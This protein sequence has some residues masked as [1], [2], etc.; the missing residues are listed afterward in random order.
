MISRR[1]IESIPDLVRELSKR[2]IATQFQ[3]CH[4]FGDE[5]NASD[6]PL[7]ED[8]SQLIET[9]ERMRAEGYL[10]NSSRPYLKQMA[11]YLRGAEVDD[12]CSA[13]YFQ[14]IVDPD[15][16]VRFCCMLPPIGTLG[17]HNL[18]TVWNSEE[19][20]KQRLEIRARECPRCW[21]MYMDTGDG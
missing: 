2:R 11:A 19:A 5:E 13:G 16:S 17:D 6:Y 7:P 10:I 14:V 21:L 18:Q 8:V 4:S 20:R 1:N 12:D 15:A 3:P 9:I